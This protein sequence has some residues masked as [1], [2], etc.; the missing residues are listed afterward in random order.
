[1]AHAL[2][3]GIFNSGQTS[4]SPVLECQTVEGKRCTG[5]DRSTPNI[6]GE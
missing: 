6:S 2:N 5:V 4:D 3:K 1:M